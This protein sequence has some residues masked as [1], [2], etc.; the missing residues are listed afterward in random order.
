MIDSFGLFLTF[1]KLR[2]DAGQYTMVSDLLDRLY[3]D[4]ITTPHN[5]YEYRRS[6]MPWFAN[7]FVRRSADEQKASDEIES[8][9]G[10]SKLRKR[11]AGPFI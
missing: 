7:R 11:E 10:Y 6:W 8:L 3:N 4:R 1:P 5:H 9:G 2:V